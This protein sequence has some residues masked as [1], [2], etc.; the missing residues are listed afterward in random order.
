MTWE[1]ALDMRLRRIFCALVCLPLSTVALGDQSTANA[2]ASSRPRS[3]DATGSYEDKVIEGLA[4]G[5]A[6][7]QN[8]EGDEAPLYDRSGW[9]RYLQ[10]E[11]RMGTR[12]FDSQHRS[13]TG[14]SAQGMLETPA[15]GVLTVNGA[16]STA[17]S[18]G[19][20]ATGGGTDPGTL[21]LRQTAVPM[22]EGALLNLEAGIG[23]PNQVPLMQLPSRIT[24]PSP[25]QRGAQIE[26]VGSDNRYQLDARVGQPGILGTGPSE[27]FTRYPGRRTGLAAQ[28][29]WGTIHA[30]AP[31]ASEADDGG[32]ILPSP[33][34]RL[35]GWTMA[36]QLEAARGVLAPITIQASPANVADDSSRLTDARSQLVALRHEQRNWAVQAKWLVGQSTA[37]ESNS[38][39]QAAWI[40]AEWREGPR[41][42]SLGIY[43]LDPG[44]SW[45]G[46]GLANDL[47]GVYYRGGW[48]RRQWSAD[49]S[50]DWLKSISGLR[51]DGWYVTL[52]GQRRLNSRHYISGGFNAR[53][54]ST[55][56][57]ASYADWRTSHDWGNSGLRLDLYGGE[58]EAEHS[59]TL[60][61]DQDWKTP[62]GWS[63][64]TSLGVSRIEDKVQ[65]TQDTVTALAISA[66]GPLGRRAE[67]GTSLSLEQSRLDRQR[68]HNVSINAS[69]AIN[70][71][72]RLTANYTRQVGQSRVRNSLDPLATPSFTRLTTTDDL[73]YY[74]GLSYTF[75]A[76]SRLLPIGGPASDGG[77]R[78]V[79][80]V[81]FDA[82][83]SGRQEASE[84]GVPGIPVM[85]DNRY[86]VLT[87]EQGKFEFALVSPGAHAITVRSDTLP[88]PWRAPELNDGQVPVSVQLR[89]EHKVFVGV[90]R[91]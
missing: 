78:V 44:L 14:F 79:G 46:Q 45:G 19:S 89:G 23:Y 71:R 41:N 77:G 57:W 87:D 82:N 50:F 20:S 9:P 54:F 68:N 37:L 63:L 34:A 51:D 81:F 72:W 40:D 28:W 59:T 55:R 42:H 66:S 27:S 49:G 85:I 60:T 53:Q 12:P 32:S 17:D 24:L 25:V 10:L 39:R 16:W 33:Y 52:S 69:W 70:H 13:T 1:G 83:G 31:G 80:V 43:R 35:P 26:W 21:T 91:D 15:H 61:Y 8:D 11:T 88:L 22:G 3:A 74:V 56:A 36:W 47:Q 90:I 6:S 29:R 84:A 7:N 5:T 18:S 76:G 30:T 86:A 64:G 73:T 65:L 2:S 67:W 58:P 4:D 48:R 62:V 75:Q 38:T